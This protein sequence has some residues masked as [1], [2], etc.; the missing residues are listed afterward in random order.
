MRKKLPQ[1]LS[2]VEPLIDHDHAREL[3]EMDRIIHAHPEILDLI[4]ADL[5][6]GLK[7]PNTGR[8]GKLSAEQVLKSFIIKQMNGFSYKILNYHLQDSRTYRSFCQFGFVDKIPS[9][10]IIQRDIKKLRPETL[11]A[12]HH[13]LM[14]GA[15]AKK[16]EKGRKVRTDCTVVES[17]IHHPSDSSLLNDSVRVLSRIMQQAKKSFGYV[18][19]NYS[20][21]AKRRAL[22]ILNAKNKKARTKLY[23]D[24]LKVS[25]KSVNAAEQVLNALEQ[26]PPTDT[27]TATGIASELQGFIPL[28][29]KVIDQAE[30]RI[31]HEEKVPATEKIFSIFEPHTDIINKDKR[32]SYYG[33]KIAI[34]GG[35]SGLLSDVVIE[36]GNPND[37][38]LATK[39]IQRQVALYGKVPK[40]AA[41]DGGFASK[42]NLEDIKKLGVK[43]V[44][45]SKKCGLKVDEMAKSA[46][47]YKQLRNFR[48]GIEGMI[49]YLKRC[50]GLTRCN[51]S[52]F[53][54]FK[55]YVWSS[56]I[57]A[58]LLL[59]ARRRLA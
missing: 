44:C 49:S 6:Y 17:N 16:I 45:F 4:Y 34:T 56:V 57:T 33:H 13:I 2:I 1:Q 51:W 29:K 27:V 53:A 41:F 47:V 23:R 32:D 39:M 30:R 3:R 25:C 10:K 55:S 5:I 20:R 8:K 14:N 58:N 12:I 19:P 21:R 37:S 35:A 28:V 26:S 38:T 40:Q 24:L 11:E 54:S 50:F 36:S 15:E 22:G 59:M 31:F 52:G 9:Y 7:D 43:D 18:V 42:E 46:W 48:A